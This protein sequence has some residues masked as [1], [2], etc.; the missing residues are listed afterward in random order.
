[1]TEEYV[2]APHLVLCV[3]LLLSFSFLVLFQCFSRNGEG[4][5]LV[6]LH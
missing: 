6:R 4:L 5:E 3:D 2:V 1:M